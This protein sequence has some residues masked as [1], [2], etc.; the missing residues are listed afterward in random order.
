[1]AE[2]VTISEPWVHDNREV[3][4]KVEGAPQLYTPA[5]KAPIDPYHVRLYYD[6]ATGETRDVIV[7]GHTWD[8]T[9]PNARWARQVRRRVTRDRAPEWLLELI[10]QYRPTYTQETTDQ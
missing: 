7:L 10:Q 6:I 1:M 9:G 3:T 4:L 5:G 2:G 8:G